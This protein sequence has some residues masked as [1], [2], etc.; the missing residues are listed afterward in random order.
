MKT[1]RITTLIIMDGVGIP[2]DLSVSGVTEK[3][4]LYLQSLAKHYPHGTLGASGAFVGLPDNQTGTSE[5]G[6]LAIGSGRVNFQPSVRINKAIEGGEFFKNKA[7][8]EAC[9]NAKKPGKALHLMGIVSD[10]GVHSH[11]DHLI[12]LIELAKRENVKKVFIHFITD[13][14]DTPPKSAKTYIKALQ[15]AINSAKV[16][17]IVDFVGRFY[18]LDRDNNWDRVKVAYDAYVDG[19]GAQTDDPISAIDTAYSNGENDE[20]LTPI[21]KFVNNK[22]VGRIKEGDSLI[23]FNFRTDRERQLARAFSNDNDFDWTKKL[24]LNL[25][26]MTNFDENLGGVNVAFDL[27]KIDNLF[28]EVLGKRGYKHLKIAETEK[29]AH[30]TFFFNAN[31]NEPFVGEDRKLIA[32]E[33]LKSYD[34]C[35]EMSANKIANEAVKGINSGNYDVVIINFANGDMVGHSGNLEA[36]RVA[37]GVVDKCVKKVAEATMK[38]GGRVIVTADHGNADIMVYPDGTQHKSHTMAEVPVIIA[39]PELYDNHKKLK[40]KLADIA[41]TILKFMGEKKPKEMTGKPLI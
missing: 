5:V 40:G 16:G 34:V 12:A 20:F 41:P 15:N 21:V 3:N 22:P 28:S 19:K 38:I 24:N 39:S 2:Q 18:A 27:V 23:I 17:E 4:T 6:H 8:I 35:P 13:G 31:N 36:T 11:I 1:D 26:T 14:R 9:E 32:S 10:G 33:K 29:F 7:F 37:V 25:V 30:L